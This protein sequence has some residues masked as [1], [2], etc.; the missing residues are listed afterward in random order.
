MIKR[1]FFALAKPEPKYPVAGTREMEVFA[2]IPLPPKVSLLVKRPNGNDDGLLIK[3]GD[4][5][6][7]GQK[8]RLAAV[9]Q[10]YLISTVTG[11]I[12]AVTPYTGYLGQV[13]VSI[14]IDVAEEERWDGEFDRAGRTPNRQNATRFLASLPGQ[15]DF[16]SLI[17]SQPPLDTFVVNGVDKDVLITTN[18]RVVQ[19]GNEQLKDGIDYLRKISGVNRIMLLVTPELTPQAERMDVEL[20]VIE[21]AYPGT[22]PKMVMKT[23]LGKEVPA[24]KTCADLG[25]GFISAEAVASLG[26]ALN[27]GQI[28]VD[29]RLTV[30]KKDGSTVNVKARI[31]TPVKEILNALQLE[32]GHG[33]RVVMGGPMTGYAIHSDD[34]PVL[35]D[36]DAIMVQDKEQITPSSDNQCI[37]CGECVRAC[38]A[39][40]PANML[41]R[42]LENAL[43]EEAVNQYDLLSC[44]ECGLCSYVCIARIPVFQY[45]M[46]GKYEFARAKSAEESNAESEA[47]H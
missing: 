36:T 26:S 34:M 11:S 38:P 22:L 3:V 14:S 40:I 42:L 31:G 46:L 23:V 12:G 44:I 21:S 33:D 8:L 39:N 28:P 4:R 2:Q 24:G 29:K 16:A 13:Y 27:E 37:N 47:I 45:I 1:W 25:V 20:R 18:Q 9:G 17:N 35:S 5:V 7:T 41:V 43:Y 19:A 15:S 32:A 30:I 6:R 10:E